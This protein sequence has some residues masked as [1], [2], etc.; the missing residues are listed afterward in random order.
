MLNMLLI[1]E[2]VKYA[3]QLISLILKKEENIRLVDIALDNE[4]ATEI[5]NK[6]KI[7]IILLDIE[8]FENE[9]LKLFDKIS[10]KNRTKYYK[11]IIAIVNNEKKLAYLK[12][13]PLIYSCILKPVV[14]KKLLQIIKKMQDYKLN[15]KRE[16]NIWENKINEQFEFLG[17]NLSHIGTKYLRECIKIDYLEYQGEAE[18]LNKQ[19]YPIV[20][21]RN[22]TTTFNVKNSIIKAN[23]YMYRQCEIKRLIKYFYFSEDRKPTPKVVMKTILN[24]L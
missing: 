14:S 20:A 3:K 9:L 2:N 5:L 1:E 12:N 24:K 8:N 11:S 16:N 19:I 21:K 13:N 4:E 15:V 23:N 7:D 18:N 22:N 17:F 10:K 6:Y